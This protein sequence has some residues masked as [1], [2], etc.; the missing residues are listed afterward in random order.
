M[1]TL[2]PV[3][4]GELFA[5][6]SSILLLCGT[7]GGSVNRH[8]VTPDTAQIAWSRDCLISVNIPLP[9]QQIVLELDE[10]VREVIGICRSSSE[11]QA[12][13]T[14]CE[15]LH[16]LFLISVATEQNSNKIKVCFLSGDHPDTI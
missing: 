1:L 10:M 5:L 3:S 16:A 6:Q 13:A 8:L 15:L 12:R 2:S 9:Q 11:G 14:S 4:A 7:L